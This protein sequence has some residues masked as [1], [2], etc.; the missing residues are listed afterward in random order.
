M[1]SAKVLETSAAGNS[2]LKA[3]EANLSYFSVNAL[4][5]LKTGSSDMYVTYGNII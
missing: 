4:Q 1:Q 5:L 2:K 3:D